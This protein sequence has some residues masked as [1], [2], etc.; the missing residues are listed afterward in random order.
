MKKKEISP[1]L[2]TA[3]RSRRNIVAIATA[4]ICLM[5][6]AMTFHVYMERWPTVVVLGV[7]MLILGWHNYR[8]IQ[9]VDALVEEIERLDKELS[10][11]E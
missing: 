4:G 9:K 6:S 10:R 5:L 1:N 7:I 8:D 3:Y 2:K 11:P